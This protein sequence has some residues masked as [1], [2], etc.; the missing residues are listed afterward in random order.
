[1]SWS[2]LQSAS[3]NFAGGTTYFPA[4]TY[5]ANLTAGTKLFCFAA[6]V[7]PVSSINSI[8]DGAS[9]TGNQL[10]AVSS[11]D[12]GGVNLTLVMY[13]MDTPAGDAGTKPVIS[14]SL[15]GKADIAF[16]I[17]EVSG[18]ASGVGGIT[19]GT[20][21]TAFGGSP[22]GSMG[23]P[24]YSSTASGEFL[25]YLY[26]DDEGQAATSNIYTWTAPGGYTVDAHSLNAQGTG[27]GY[28]NNLAVAYKN[29]TGGTETGA[30]SASGS[31]GASWSELLV[32]FK[33]AGG[34]STNT[35]PAWATSYDIVS[36]GAGSWVNPVDAEGTGGSSGPWATWTAP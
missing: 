1:M 29:S 28:I 11:F 15:T 36:G 5:T 32:A 33:L 18:L 24:S 31:G 21:G 16:L 7:G 3:A 20:A 34:G 23:P 13:A 17:Q 10:T 6:I 22:S 19:D 26:G 35:S 12:G 9:G 14:A 25:V 27:T 8:G 4:A 2:V 30:W